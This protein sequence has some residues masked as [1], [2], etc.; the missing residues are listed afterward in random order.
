MEIK[1]NNGQSGGPYLSIDNDGKEVLR[2]YF[3]KDGGIIQVNGMSVG[4]RNG[5]RAKENQTDFEEAKAIDGIELG[6]I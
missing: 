6:K 4:C 2:A 3:M 5:S 1:L